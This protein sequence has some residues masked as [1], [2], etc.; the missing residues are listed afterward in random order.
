MLKDAPVFPSQQ[1]YN[2]EHGW[3]QTY[4]SGITM[5]DYFAIHALVG[6]GTWSPALI[7]EDK[8]KKAKYAYEMADA[9]LKARDV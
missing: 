2:L 6:M 5:R 9:M 4:S 8:S 3:N 7:D 1:D